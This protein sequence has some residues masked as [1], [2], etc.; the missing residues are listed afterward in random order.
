[1]FSGPKSQLNLLS[2]GETLTSVPEVASLVGVLETQDAV[3][4]DTDEIREDVRWKGHVSLH[5]VEENRYWRKEGEKKN[6]TYCQQDILGDTD[7]MDVKEQQAWSSQT[8]SHE[9]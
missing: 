6:K 5:L 1:M 4:V 9:Y 3:I 8:P 2:N 7:Y